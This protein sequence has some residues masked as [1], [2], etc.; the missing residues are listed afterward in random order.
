MNQSSYRQPGQ[1]G[2]SAMGQPAWG[3]QIWDL[4]LQTNAL[5]NVTYTAQLGL[6]SQAPQHAAQQMT[7]RNLRLPESTRQFSTQRPFGG[8]VSISS[9]FVVISCSLTRRAFPQAHYEYPQ[10]FQP[11]S[12]PPPSRIQPMHPRDT[13]SAIDDWDLRQ[14][15]TTI[16]NPG[17]SR[18]SQAADASS[19]GHP[20]PVMPLPSRASSQNFEPVAH[21]PLHYLDTPPAPNSITDNDLLDILEQSSQRVGDSLADVGDSPA[22]TSSTAPSSYSTSDV[23]SFFAGPSHSSL[24][25]MPRPHSWWHDNYGEDV[26]ETLFGVGFS[27]FLDDSHSGQSSTTQQLEE[28]LDDV[29]AQWSPAPALK[30]KS[31][32]P[33]TQ[34]REK[35]ARKDDPQK[36]MGWEDSTRSTAS[37]VQR[38]TRITSEAS[39]SQDVPTSDEVFLSY[40]G[41]NTGTATPVEEETREKRRKVKRVKEGSKYKPHLCR[42]EGCKWTESFNRRRDYYRHVCN[43]TE[44]EA[45]R[46]V[47]GWRQ[48]HGIPEDFEDTQVFCPVENCTQRY[49]GM[50]KDTM[51]SHLWKQHGIGEPPKKRAKKF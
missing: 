3:P 40:S 8:Q 19:L 45:E 48:R 27:A 7:Q 9:S 15:A 46:S 16:G 42:I 14:P 33:S 43:N 50:R 41:V 31:T 18:T 22:G 13:G 38:D 23:I 5:R 11:F 21:R 26:Y 32:A 29:L 35:R 44:H 49:H 39:T 2:Q 34:G 20:R 10:I 17:S 6:S 36:P 37:Q 1:T 51:K 4:E 12:N 30:R 28:D 25:N 47:P 24:D